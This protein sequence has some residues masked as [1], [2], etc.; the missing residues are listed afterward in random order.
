MG[1]GKALLDC[2]AATGVLVIELSGRGGKLIY[3]VH[4]S[5]YKL[6]P[7][8]H[9]LNL[10]LRPSPLSSLLFYGI[11]SE[12]GLINPSFPISVSGS[13]SKGI[14]PATHIDSRWLSSESGGS[15]TEG[16]FPVDVL[17]GKTLLGHSK[18]LEFVLQMTKEQ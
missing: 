12:H 16:D 1:S 10:S 3:S 8:C 9:V 5:P 15:S 4:H 7:V 14:Q 11:L 17:A 18:S 6:A 2:V 13:L